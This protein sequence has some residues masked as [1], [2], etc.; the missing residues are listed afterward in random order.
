M[1]L[2]ATRTTI[3]NPLQNMKKV[4]IRSAGI[5]SAIIILALIA[6]EAVNYSTTA[7]ALR[8]LLGN[9]KFAGIRWSVL[10]ALAFCGLD[11]AGVARLVTQKGNSREEKNSWYLFGAWLIAATFNAALTWWGVSIAVSNHALRSA[12]VFNT[13]QLTTIVPVMV[14]IMVWVIRVLIIG[15]LTSSLEKKS[16][17]RPSTA[18]TTRPAATTGI[19]ANSHPSPGYNHPQPVVSTARMMNNRST[20]PT[21][22][23]PSVNRY[24]PSSSEYSPTEAQAV[25]KV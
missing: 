12:E 25:R 24:Q 5:Y 3:N 15:S 6:F 11:F 8:D 21:M 18:K 7:Y 19:P 16:S 20:T 2:T 9:L 1:N 17:T 13:Q 10:L 23:R 4:K 22:A 14:A